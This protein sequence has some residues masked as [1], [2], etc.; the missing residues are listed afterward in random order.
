M[1]FTFLRVGVIAFALTLVCHGQE[2]TIKVGQSAPDFVA[3]G[4]DGKS[5]RLSQKLKKGKSVA[6]M[7]SRAHW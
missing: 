7:F 6:L 3:T 5:F 2:K 1:S 4:I